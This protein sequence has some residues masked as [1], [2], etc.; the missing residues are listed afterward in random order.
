MQP[1]LNILIF[2][3]FASLLSLPG[4][5][6]FCL[7]IMSIFGIYYLF[8]N[9]SYKFLW[10]NSRQRYLLI[11]LAL[12]F[13]A[14]LLSQLFRLEL[15]LK[16]YDSPLRFLLCI[17]IIHL[18]ARFKPNI[19][20]IAGPACVAGIYSSAVNVAI[21]DASSTIWGGRLA[22][23]F[24]DPN[25]FGA[26]LACFLCFATV[27]TI[28]TKNN[29]HKIISFFSIVLGCYMLAKTNTRAA[30]LGY[31]IAILIL[32]F[33]D[34]KK[35][36]NYAIGILTFIFIMVLA[37]MEY[38][39]VYGTITEIK[40][41][42]EPSN[43]K[44]DTS[45]SIRLA[46]LKLALLGILNSP[47]AGYGDNNLSHLI[48]I[49]NHLTSA[50]KNIIGAAG[51]HNEILANGVRSGV[52]GLISSSLLFITPTVLIYKKIANKNFNQFDLGLFIT[53]FSLFICSLSIEIFT[54]KFTASFYGLLMSY[55]SISCN[56]NPN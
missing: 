16:A 44:V 35:N 26:Y 14:I 7:F 4:V 13:C 22:P 39:R 11:T 46:M 31:L 45:L 52:L 41:L 28:N 5:T 48:S 51:V 43:E 37:S 2:I 34:K 49:S 50:E 3:S 15:V 10:Q 6:N 32:A 19:A 8:Q 21:S 24:G 30:W 36:Q 40:H 27:Y 47:L 20:A 17:P 55:L 25:S 38:D 54:L 1:T 42:I 12:P 9:N 18:L 23:S 29:F 33:V 53:I 56:K